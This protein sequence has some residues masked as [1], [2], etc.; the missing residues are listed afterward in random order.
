MELC[1]CS[2]FFFCVTLLV[3][4]S[5]STR[6]SQNHPPQLA[7]SF[8][9]TTAQEDLFSVVEIGFLLKG[10]SSFRGLVLKTLWRRCC[11]V[12]LSSH[13]RGS[14]YCHGPSGRVGLMDFYQSQYDPRI[15]LSCNKRTL[16]A[17]RPSVRILNG[18]VQSS[19]IRDIIHKNIIGN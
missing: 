15:S 16:K 19:D 10:G 3:I 4:P 11:H 6:G 13:E 9:A 18:H 14:I 8:T 12:E 1:S 7:T 5:V 17:G 2:F